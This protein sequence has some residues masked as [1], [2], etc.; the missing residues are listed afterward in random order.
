MV[1]G[2]PGSP[3]GGFDLTLER[4]HDL[5]AEHRIVHRPGLNEELAA[6]TVWGSQMGAAVEYA[7]VDGVVGAWYGKAPGLDRSGD[8]L[9]HA[10]A[11][12]AGPNGGVVHVLR[13]RPVGQVVDPGVRQP[14]HLRGRLRAG[15]VPG[16][17]AGRPRPRRPRVPRCRATSGAWVGLKIVTV[18]GRR[19]RHR[20][21]RP[22]SARTRATRRD[23]VI[24]GQPWRHHP[25]ATIGPHQ[26]PDQEAL[27]VEHRLRAAQAYARAQ[28]ARPRRGRRHRAR[29]LGHRV[30]RQDLLRRRA[31]ARRPRAS[32]L[33]DLDR[34]GIRVLKLAMTYPLVAETVR[35]FA[36][37]VDDDRRHRGEAAV[38][39]DA[40]AQHP[41]RGAAAPSRCRA[42]A[43]A[44][45]TVLASSV[46]ELDPPRSPTILARVLPVARVAPRAGARPR[47]AAPAA[48]ELPV[49][50][51]AG[52]LQRLPAQ[53][54]D[55]RSRPAR[56]SAAASAATGSCT[57]RPATAGMKSLAAHAD[58]RGGR[59]VDRPR[60][61]RRRAAPDPEHRR[62]H[63]QPL[64][65]PRHP[66]QRRRG[67][68]HHVQDPLQRRR[69]HD[70]RA[71][72]HRPDGRAVA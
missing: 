22:G 15:A 48:A 44:T 56:W 47:H 57:S 34:L 62:R 71:G 8:V 53:P 54:L 69:R 37:S 41:P 30:R 6:A 24:D 64:G 3:L 14:A 19:H 42:S 17:P 13:R 38:R 61:V 26:V 11:M 29:R 68:R 46:G 2:Y 25:L 51:R 55:G 40:A 28:R 32:S 45:A 21:P 67:R 65:H 60:A 23:L 39:R 7:E 70:R 20:R 27:V 36:D 59:A 50:A 12:G 43:T 63:A 9:K 16:R 33:D 35:E 52:L 49:P 58:G 10:N 4:L 18:G 31:G 1:S 5:L 66:G 72:R